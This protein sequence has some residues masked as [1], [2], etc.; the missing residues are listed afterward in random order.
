M[1]FRARSVVVAV[2]L[3]AAAGPAAGWG[4][5]PKITQA[6]LAVVPEMERWNAAL[7][8]KNI[9]E[10]AQHCWLPDMRGMDLGTHYA[11]DYLLIPALPRH[12]DHVMPGVRV[13]FEPYFRRAVR[14]LRTE[15][16]V[17]AC[18]QIGPILHFVEDVG[19]PPHAREKCPHHTEL[20]NWVREE[21]IVIAGY[22]P[23]L[24]GKTED[25]ALAGLLKR[26][27][28]LVEF[29]RAR[30]ERALPLVSVEKPDRSQIEPI[31]LESALE[32]AR[33][34]ADLLYIALHGG[35]GADRAGGGAAG[36]EG[37]GG[38]AAPAEQPR[39]AGGAAGR[40]VLDAGHD[41]GGR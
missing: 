12:V 32:S 31:I 5:H 1:C 11:D 16:P 33:V 37:Q 20:E 28:G 26:L 29:S 10:L 21:Q 41:P 34:A 14:A 13:A 3:V 27:E 6:A 17:N 38:G 4:P 35:P 22:R 18:R 15:T 39:G 23:R 30:A 24:L 19:A 8:E 36:R 25:E 2:V 7:G 9:R 40:R